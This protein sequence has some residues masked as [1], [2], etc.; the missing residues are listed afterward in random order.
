MVDA[1]AR[2]RVAAI[3][4]VPPDPPDAALLVVAG[5]GGGLGVYLLTEAYRHATAVVVEPLDY[6]SVL[7]AAAF[8]FWPCNEVPGSHL[9]GGAAL[10]AGSGIYI[11]RRGVPPSS[12]TG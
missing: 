1:D 12:N 9:L 4:W 7:W 11:L 8:G 10:I 5:L 2:R 3:D 6:L